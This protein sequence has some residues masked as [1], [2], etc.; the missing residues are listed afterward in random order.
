MTTR[1]AVTVLTAVLMTAAASAQE[2]A[3]AAVE[4]RY[5]DPI[6]GL[7]LEQAIARALGQEP[8]L[9]AAR[10][11]IDVARGARLQASLRPNPTVSFERREEPAGTDN[12]TTV[13]A[14]WPLDLF[15]RSRRVAVADRELAAVQ[16]TVEDRERV[17]A[18][19]VRMRYGELIAAVRESVIL[20]QL[21]GATRRQHE[22]L[23]S[24][25]ETGAAPPLERD[26]LEVELRRLESARLLQTARTEEALF[27]LKRILAMPPDAALKVRNT[28]EELVQ[29]QSFTA[30]P[31][32]DASTIVDRRP[33]VR[34]AAARVEAAEARIDRARTE[35]RFDASLVV[36]YMRMDAGFPQRGFTPGGDLERV[37]G[38]FNYFSAGA[39]IA[40]PLRNR[41]QGGITT[42]TAQRA[43]AEA[44]LAAV[45]LEAAAELAAARTRDALAHQAVN[46]YAAGAQVLAR[47]NLTVV[48]ETYELGRLTVFDVIAEQR[49]YLDV[50]GAYTEALKAAYDA[51]TALTRAMGGV[52]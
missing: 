34:E 44:A 33:D 18:A 28:L 1:I 22:L 7:S 16:L 12:Q 47:R 32:I 14:E 43:G 23:H 4:A 35:G 3:P 15:R 49:R 2:L 8:S 37:R 38:V 46:A 39:M 27:E 51:R 41:N 45:R 11:E 52:R 26:V 48:S 31:A 29:R 19:E 9:R 20:D 6:D 10:T 50:E 17:L 40:V 42:A 25:V 13:G 24:R 21:V 36:T 5:L 30:V